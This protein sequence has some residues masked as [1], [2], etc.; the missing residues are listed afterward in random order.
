MAE[1]NQNY[2]VIFLKQARE[3]KKNEEQTDKQ[4]TSSK[5]LGFNLTIFT[6]VLNVNGLSTSLDYQTGE[7]ARPN[8]TQPLRDHF[9]GEDTY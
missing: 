2:K 6:V 4:K 8:Y 7:K 1:I 9:K 3:E 5:I